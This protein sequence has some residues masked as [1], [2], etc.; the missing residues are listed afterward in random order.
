MDDV[1]ALKRFAELPVSDR[2]GP[3]IGFGDAPMKRE[4]ECYRAVVDGGIWERG[5]ENG[6]DVRIRVG[7]AEVEEAGT[8]PDGYSFVHWHEFQ[9]NPYIMGQTWTKWAEDGM[10]WKRATDSHNPHGIWLE[11]WRERPDVMAPH[12][13]PLTWEEPA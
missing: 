8:P 2:K 11:V 5:Y 10:T 1:A 6:R 7:D 9:E 3:C 12:N 13:P 4:G